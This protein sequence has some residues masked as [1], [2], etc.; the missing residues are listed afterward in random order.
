M[1]LVRGRGARRRETRADDD[2]QAREK[3]DQAVEA[4]RVQYAP[5]I[6]R[7]VT[8]VVWQEDAEAV[9]RGIR[10]FDPQPGAWSTLRG[11]EIK[12]FGARPVSGTGLPGQVLA[13]APELTIAAGEGAVR[14]G[15][16]K[17]SGKARMSAQD[18]VHGRG[19]EAAQVFE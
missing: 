18:W 2:L 19:V 15:E 4:L 10:A 12:L 14:I 7:E 8:R 3:R 9:S 16:V 11:H 13:V 6:H 1:R 5:K 17:P